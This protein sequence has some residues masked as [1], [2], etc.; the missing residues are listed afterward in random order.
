MLFESLVK[1]KNLNLNPSL[2]CW[3]DDDLAKIEGSRA[4]PSSLRG[5]RDL[6]CKE[7]FHTFIVLTSS[8]CF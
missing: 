2:L 7:L 4:Y 5:Y 3:Y 8:H 1:V 6:A